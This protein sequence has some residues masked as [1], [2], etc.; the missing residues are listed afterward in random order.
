MRFSF[1]LF[2]LGCLPPLPDMAGTETEPDSAEVIPGINN[3]YERPI[4]QML[5]NRGFEDR[6]DADG[7]TTPSLGR[8]SNE[9]RALGFLTN[10]GLPAVRFKPGVKPDWLFEEQI[11]GLKTKQRF[12]RVFSPQMVDGLPLWAS[13]TWPRAMHC[14]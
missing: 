2:S 11:R 7:V 9:S 14:R 1:V 3:G 10:G 4:I 6:N 12:I 5:E 8:F 13:H